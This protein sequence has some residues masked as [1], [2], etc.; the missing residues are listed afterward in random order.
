MSENKRNR[1]S[2]QN[3][4]H[5][6][7]I[8]TIELLIESYSFPKEPRRPIILAKK[9]DRDDKP[10]PDK[11][12]ILLKPK[13]TQDPNKPMT[14]ISIASRPVEATTSNV[15]ANKLNRPQPTSASVSRDSKEPHVTTSDG[16]S[17]EKVLTTMKIPYPI[18]SDHYQ[19]QNHAQDFLIET[20][21]DFVVIGVIGTKGSGKSFILNM[22]VDDKLEIDDADHI[23]KLLNGRAG[24]F[25][26]RNQMKELLS[27]V[28]ATEGIQIYITKNRTIL[29]DCSPVLCNPYKKD[30]ILNELDDLKMLIFLLSVCNTL[31]VVEDC[32]FNMSLVRL[33]LMAETMKVHVYENDLNACQYS[34]NILLFKNKC[35]N[36]DFLVEARQ[37]TT[38]MYRTFFKCSGTQLMHSSR[39][40][41]RRSAT[42]T[43]DEK[44]LDVFYFPL[45]D[46]CSKTT[47]KF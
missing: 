14:Q 16:A 32:G 39:Q 25:P 36:R 4:V 17:N 8:L 15:D 11:P 2:N 29:L 10:T 23:N 12:R 45:L 28:P 7:R 13:T 24:V 21:T 26:M 35:Q 3:K 31:I 22:L 18:I 37:R 43:N 19:I 41:D 34:P 5:F 6:F 40:L 44:Q 27:N 46:G 1:R 42:A 20:N 33:L 38:N 47:L 30:A 9:T